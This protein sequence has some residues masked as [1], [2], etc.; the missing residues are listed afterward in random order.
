MKLQSFVAGLGIAVSIPFSLN[1][2][3]Q[4]NVQLAEAYVPGQANE[5]IVTA[6]RSPL[7]L[8]NALASSTVITR[9][10]IEKSQAPDLY[11][12]LQT[13]AGV[14]VKR[15]GGPG[16][17]TTVSMRGGNTSGTLIMVDGVN[18]ESATLG[19]VALEQLSLD[20][21]DRIEI[22]R[23]PKSSLYGASAMNGVIQ[24][25]TRKA[26]KST[27]IQYSLGYGS[28]NTR[29][30]SVSASG[31]TKTSRFN[32]TASHVASDGYDLQYAD[33]AL[34]SSPKY[35]KDKDGYHRSA[36]SLYAEQDMGKYFTADATLQRTEGASDYDDVYNPDSFPSSLYDT[37]LASTGLK[38]ELGNVMS[39]LQYSH[40][41]DKSQT[42]GTGYDSLYQTNRDKGSWEN[43][44]R[45]LDWLTLNFG[46]DYTH[47]EV[48][49]S[50]VYTQ[51]RRDNFGGYANTR[52]EAGHFSWNLGMRHDNNEQFG[53]KWTG[54]TAVGYEIAS[55][56]ILSASYGTAFK[57]PSFNDL[58]YPSL[59]WG[60]GNPNLKPEET[61]STE[62]G[63]DLHQDW[64]NASVHIY[65][66][67]VAQLIEWMETAPYY[68][69]P[70]NVD[71]VYIRGAE[72]QYGT[73]WLGL[74]LHTSFTY[75]KVINQATGQDI[76]FKPRRRG[77]LD[78]DKQLNQF[79]VGMT[80]YAQSSQLEDQYAAPGVHLTG[81]GKVNLRASWQVSKEVKLRARAANVF[82][83]QYIPQKGYN[84]PGRSL[85]VFVDYTPS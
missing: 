13:V 70:F 27:G 14:S 37:L 68:S 20:E 15:S 83:N 53:S 21:I 42:Q 81:Y 78:V 59:P 25:F 6:S 67:K 7:E 11:S 17:A 38:L 43:S 2:I 40:F 23:G 63:L 51:T 65:K 33:D 19:E 79:S 36:I 74:D 34:A 52:V 85:M 35:G 44:V 80:I 10:Q 3:A 29:Q 47:D 62:I 57:A 60:K 55:G 71:S 12:L 39:H 66:S 4:E 77:A 76:Q 49:S 41:Q 75:E 9:E 45:A 28:D 56:A 72:L 50:E 69:E 32:L 16:S 48:A 30:G 26:A 31:V 18:I 73:R 58:Y 64:G 84:N 1:A 61:K 22:V 8:Q 24:I 82:D 46:M 5:I 54:D